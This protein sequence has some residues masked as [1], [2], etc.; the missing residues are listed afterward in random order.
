MTRR[1]HLQAATAA[2]AGLAAAP[3]E[4]AGN[5]IQL[6]VDLDVDPAKEK[7]LLNNFRTIFQPTIRK[8]AGF[9][10]VKLLKLHQVMAGKGPENTAYR[11]LIGFQTE[12]Q[13]LKWVASDD[14]RKVWP[15]M[16]ENLRGA[17]LSAVLFDIA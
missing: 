2:L 16:D 12:D 8:Q 7:N 4:A 6:H 5:P 1:K 9:V 14:H 3:A 13:R 15:K 17:K 11:L 10:D